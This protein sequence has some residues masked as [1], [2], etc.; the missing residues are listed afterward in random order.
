MIGIPPHEKGPFGAFFP[1]SYPRLQPPE[2]SKTEN[3]QRTPP[4]PTLMA[5]KALKAH[6]S[7]H[8][9]HKALKAQ[10]PHIWRIGRLSRRTFTRSPTKQLGTACSTEILVID[11][12]PSDRRND[13]RMRRS[14]ALVD[15]YEGYDPSVTGFGV[16]VPSISSVFSFPLY[17]P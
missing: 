12:N 17:A 3:R 4:N 1:A 6:T 8:T 13:H 11:G 16:S 9:A 7:T 10:L 5:H 2:R 14:N 15:N